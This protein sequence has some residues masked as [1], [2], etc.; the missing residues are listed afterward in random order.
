L[1]SRTILSI[2]FGK[3]FR[4][5]NNG[6]TVPVPWPLISETSLD[7]LEISPNPVPSV[8]TQEKADKFNFWNNDFMD[9]A[10]PTDVL[11]VDKQYKSVE[12]MDDVEFEFGVCVFNV[13]CDF[14]I[15]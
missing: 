10:I 7:Y 5:P 3:Y 13:I 9:V 4:D 14:I 2:S 11:V 6:Q 1:I 12:D 15:N 8:V